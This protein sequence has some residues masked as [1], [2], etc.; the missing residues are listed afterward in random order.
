MNRT[1]T[2]L[3]TA[4]ALLLAA[5]GGQGAGGGEAVPSPDGD[6]VLVEGTGPDGPIPIVDDQPPTLTIDG[7]DWGGTICNHYGSTV[8]LD[9]QQLAIGD[10]ARTEMA[11]LDETVMASEDAYLTAYVAADRFTVDAGELTLAGDGVELRYA[12][13]APEPDAPV[14]GTRWRLDAIVE[15][16]GPD[17]AV[18]SVLGDGS[19]VLE[20]GRLRGETGCN[21]FGGAYELDGDRL[22]L[23]DALEVTTQ[24]C[25]E[26]LERQLEH[27]LAVL[28]S[29][30]EV[31]IEGTRLV[32]TAPEGAG[33]HYRAD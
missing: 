1:M 33:L 28:A 31:R 27:V 4:L 29:D 25:D 23:S 24:G 26:A 17:G 32:L 22:R 8:E 5:C 14:E 11:C 6:W 30:P 3:T 9:G 18:S 12:T 16:G 7:S 15:G 19:L 21:S 10:V 20:D 13:V 2:L